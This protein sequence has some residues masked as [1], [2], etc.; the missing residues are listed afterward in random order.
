MPPIDLKPLFDQAYEAWPKKVERKKSSD[1]FAKAA[2]NR[3]PHE[4]AADVVRFGQAY[5]ATTETR[6]IPALVV[7][8]N[9]ERWTDELP[10][11]RAG[12]STAH[13]RAAA[14]Q[15]AN[16]AVVQQFR[17]LEAS[18]TNIWELET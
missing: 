12:Q 17:D 5:A 1:A 8:L 2:R 4:L 10:R 3:D 16:M 14:R 9:G 18:E 7:W 15:A 6:F 13:E 11:P